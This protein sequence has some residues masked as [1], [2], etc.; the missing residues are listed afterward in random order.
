[1]YMRRNTS[2]A[3]QVELQRLRQL[4]ARVGSD[5]LLTQASTGN[6]SV[7]IDGVLWMKAS[8]KWMADA[9]RDDILIPLD[10]S[11]ITRDCLQHGINPA[12]RYPGASVETAMHAA[13]P[14]RV[15]LHLHC[16]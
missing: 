6:S 1:M 14:H 4:T 11:E 2:A 15:V 9:M 12:E 10:W 8:G 13:L 3:S 16:V 7:K 5:P